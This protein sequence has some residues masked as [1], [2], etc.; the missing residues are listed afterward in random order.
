[1]KA[2]G[3]GVASNVNCTLG[4]PCSYLALELGNPNEAD[5]HWVC[6]IKCFF[7]QF[8]IDMEFVAIRCGLQ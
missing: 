1:M 6:K 4:T 2:E 8:M 3:M 7:L 5:W